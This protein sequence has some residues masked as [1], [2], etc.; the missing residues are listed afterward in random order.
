M[1]LNNSTG[2]VSFNEA[3]AV[4][5]PLTT[6]TSPLTCL[7]WSAGGTTGMR[8]SSAIERRRTEAADEGSGRVKQ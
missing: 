1:S 4:E 5:L 7:G 2:I 6:I 3:A 8:T